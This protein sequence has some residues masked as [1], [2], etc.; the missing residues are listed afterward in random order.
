M[1]QAQIANAIGVSGSL[2]SMYMNDH[3]RARGWHAFERKIINIVLSL[4]K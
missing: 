3:R 4:N 1:T 2:I